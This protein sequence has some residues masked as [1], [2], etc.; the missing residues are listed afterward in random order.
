MVSRGY[1]AEFAEQ[2]FRQIQGFGEYG[3]PESHSASFALLVYVSAWL[4]RHEP[5]AFLCAMLNSQPMGF[6]SA[7]QLI[8]DARRHGVQ[9]RPVDVTIS[10][11][12]CTL[13]EADTSNQSMEFEPMES[14]QRIQPIVRLGLNRIK[15]MGR[16]ATKRIVEAR[17][18]APFENTDDLANRALLNA[19]EIRALA[20]SDALNTLS[21]HRRQSLWAVAP[22][23]Q[24]HDLMRHALVKEALPVIPAAPEGKEIL[25]DYHST[26][27]TLRRH[28]LALLRPK[29]TRMNLR[30]A[31][32]LDSC[33]PG[34]LVHTT[35]IVTCRQ[36]PGSA[37]G[38]MFVTLEDETG[39][40]N[41]I[42]WNPIILKQ[43]REALG[44]RLLTV[45]G[46]WQSESGVKH[47]IAKRLVEHSHLLGN[48]AVEQPGFCLTE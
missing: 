4:K 16:E 12:E 31:V 40:I 37:N 46:V 10:D 11:R 29:L 23:V 6:Y 36:R 33:L 21:G 1:K 34:R 47:V 24:Q 44:S 28:P 41:V 35:G 43:R 17:N 5:A 20:S 8:Q 25:A 7:S 14:E 38:V 18:L 30:S 13:E 39:I 19:A 45:H 15:G 22:H 3:F 9:I 26:G 48:L 42:L 2:I 32:E 27:L